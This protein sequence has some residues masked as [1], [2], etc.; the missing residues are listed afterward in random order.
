MHKGRSYRL[1]CHEALP[2]QPPP[3]PKTTSFKRTPGFSSV[4]ETRACNVPHW[5]TVDESWPAAKQGVPPDLAL[6]FPPAL[7]QSHP[8]RATSLV[9]SSWNSSSVSSSSST[10]PHH[11]HRGGSLTLVSP[12]SAHN[13][14]KYL[15]GVSRISYLYLSQLQDRGPL[16]R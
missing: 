8:A 14:G 6:D 1:W 11:L 4:K 13:R 5:M 9:P 7:S 15:H 16:G 3:A 12:F 2:R 10:P